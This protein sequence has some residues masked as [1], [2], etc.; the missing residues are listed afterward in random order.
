M[1]FPAQR[2]LCPIALSCGLTVYSCCGC[3]WFVSVP[4]D[5]PAGVQ[6]FESHRCEDFPIVSDFFLRN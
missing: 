2:L 3:G 1:H 5:D 6:A 4:S